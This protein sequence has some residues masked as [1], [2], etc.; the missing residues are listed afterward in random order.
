[1]DQSNYKNDLLEPLTKGF[2]LI[3]FNG[4]LD[5][6]LLRMGSNLYIL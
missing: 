5:F 3:N 4:E 6:R 1:M 2:I